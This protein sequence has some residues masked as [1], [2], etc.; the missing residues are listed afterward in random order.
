MTLHWRRKLAPHFAQMPELQ[1]VK[2]GPGKVKGVQLAHTLYLWQDTNHNGRSE[3]GELHTLAE[4]GLTALSLDYK[5]SARR[6][7][8]GNRFLYRGRV[9]H[10]KKSA[11]ERWAYDVFLLLDS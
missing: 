8:Y 2:I 1:E 5:Q 7:Q 6:D 3:P 9:Q 4:L 11:V 10:S